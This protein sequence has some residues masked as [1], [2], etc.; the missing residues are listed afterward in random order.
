[1]NDRL[2][3]SKPASAKAYH[4]ASE[5]EAAAFDVAE[6]ERD[7]IRAGLYRLHQYLRPDGSL[8]YDRYRTIQQAGNHKKIESVW[9]TEE[10]IAFLAA[11]LLRVIDTPSRG[12]C[13][14]TRRGAEQMWFRKHLPGCDVFGTEISDTATQ[15]PHT[16]QWDFHD[17]KPEWIGR[18]DFIYSNSFDH[19]YDPGK[20]LDAWMSCLRRGG[21]CIIEHSDKHGAKASNQLDPFGAD[22]VVMPYLIALWG[23]GRYALRE[24]VSGPPREKH[25]P[26]F[27]IVQHCM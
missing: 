10:N 1:M 12:I 5:T 7:M 19:S 26:T 2:D 8:D 25:T 14:G 18:F 24:M 9:A 27:L 23:S 20:C 3:L 22:L 16:I 11:Y 13:H 4:Q 17:V 15:F 21:A 6:R